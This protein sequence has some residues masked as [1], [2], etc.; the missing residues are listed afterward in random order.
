MSYLYQI[1]AFHLDITML[2]ERSFNLT[3]RIKEIY[4]YNLVGR[5]IKPSQL[6]NSSIST[7]DKEKVD[8]LRVTV[9]HRLWEL[10]I[11]LI[12]GIT[13]LVLL[14]TFGEV[15]TTSIISILF[16]IIVC[17]VTLVWSIMEIFRTIK[18]LKIVYNYNY[19]RLQYGVICTKYI[20]KSISSKSTSNSYYANVV[21]NENQE[22][23]RKVRFFTEKDYE[24]LNK[25]DKILVVSYDGM[26]AYIINTML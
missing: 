11:M 12:I 2:I 20:T 8:T 18:R 1:V 7:L 24:A 16:M 13:I 9:I 25:S 23:I 4:G 15:N 10:L 6:P 14:F 21:F 3:S 19:E 22:Y 5:E 26:E 17:I